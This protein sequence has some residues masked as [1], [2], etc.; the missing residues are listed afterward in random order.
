[1]SNA[2]LPADITEILLKAKDEQIKQMN[3]QLEMMAQLQEEIMELKQQ[4]R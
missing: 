4:V 1:M 3:R 2:N